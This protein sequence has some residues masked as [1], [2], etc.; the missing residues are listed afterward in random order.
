MKCRGRACSG[1]DAPSLCPWAQPAPFQALLPLTG[2]TWWQEGD[3]SL[4]LTSSLVQVQQRGFCWKMCRKSQGS[5]RST[6]TPRNRVCWLAAL[7]LEQKLPAQESLLPDRGDAQR[8]TGSGRQERRNVCWGGRPT[9]SP[10]AWVTQ[11]CWVILCVFLS[12]LCEHLLSPW[13]LAG[14]GDVK[15][16]VTKGLETCRAG[17]STPDA[18]RA[19]VKESSQSRWGGNQE[20]GE[21][22]FLGDLRRLPKR[23][24]LGLEKWRGSSWPGG[25]WRQWRKGRG[26]PDTSRNLVVSL[27]YWT[28][29]VRSRA[30]RGKEMRGIGRSMPRWHWCSGE[31]TL[32]ESTGKKLEAGW[33]VRKLLEM[34]AERPYRYDRG[35]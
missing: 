34:N 7:R 20:E 23:D 14:V 28:Q 2:S 12:V 32:E 4:T 25:E 8:K 22:C 29:W 1:L 6:E 24:G 15:I 18:V 16:G 5:E 26:C 27:Q 21:K 19:T 11:L 33:L 9:Y 17:L 35:G 31:I 13:Y 10:Q 3:S 30:D